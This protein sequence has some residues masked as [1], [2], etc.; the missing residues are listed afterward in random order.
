MKAWGI[1]TIT[2]VVGLGFAAP[3]SA[4]DAQCFQN[5][6]YLVIAQQRAEEVGSDF[7]IR[8]PAVGKIACTFET[9]DGDI[10]IG[11][12]EDPLYFTGLSRNYLVLTRSTGQDGNLVIYDLDAGAFEPIV[13][14]PADD[15]VIVGDNAV[16][17][18]ERTAEGNEDNCPEFAEYSG[19]GFGAV[20]AEERILD[21]ATGQ[22]SATGQSHCSSTQ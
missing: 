18:W 4:Y 16:T 14:L 21:T 19:Y 13:D 9:R 15:E 12:Y 22:I 1:L 7:I 8:P 3:A 11:E 17:Y 2:A 5:A 6:H 10:R 20:I